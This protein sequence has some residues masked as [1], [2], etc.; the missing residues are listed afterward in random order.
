MNQDLLIEIGTEELPPKS[1]QDLQDAF[2]AGLKQQ[3]TE[4]GIGYGVVTPFCTPRRLAVLLTDVA[5]SQPDRT[6]VRRGPAVAAAFGADEAPT[7][8]LEGFA[9]SCGVGV[10]QL[11]RE[12]NEKGE[13]M[14]F[15]T[16]ERGK[17]TRD[18]VPGVVERAL[19]GLPIAKRMRWGAGEAEFVRPVHWVC[20]LLG[21]EA[22]AGH[23]LG[24]ECGTVT[25]GHRFQSPKALSVG[26][27]SD[28]ASVLRERGFV[29][30][31]FSARRSAIVEQIGA[32]ASQRAVVVDLPDDL[33]DEVTALVEWPRAL[34]GRFEMEFLSVP[35]E[36]LIETMQKNQKYFSVRDRNGAL[37]PEFVVIA[38]IASSDPE[39]V[40]RGNER[41]IRPRFSDAKFFW[42]LGLKTPLGDYF[43]K[44]ENIVYQEKLGSVA[45]RCRRVAALAGEIAGQLGVDADLVRRAA[46][47][48]KCDLATAMVGEFPGLQGTMGRYYAD[49]SGEA[50]EVCAA[51]E[52]QYLPRFAGDAL[53]RSRVGSLLALADRLDLVV[54]AFGI[55]QGPSGT[56]DPYGIRRAA[57]GIVR[58]LVE[59]PVPIALDHLLTAAVRNFGALMPRDGVSAEAGAYVLGRLAGYFAEQGVSADT[60]DAVLA[61]GVESLSD[62]AQRVRAVERFRGMPGAAAL[63]SSNK[64]IANILEKV[65]EEIG[66]AR[67]LA[68][69]LLCEEAE[70]GLLRRIETL[71]IEVL[72]LMERGDYDGALNLLGGLREQVDA[73][74]DAV[75]VMAEDADLRKNR[76]RLLARLRSLFLRV[77]DVSLLQ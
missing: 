64:R 54:G 18:L 35:P 20:I 4:L 29:E 73:F 72:P 6:L 69:G 9:R 67:L 39:V 46:M 43:A 58:L 21:D 14:A 52:E 7:K 63:A 31:S 19:R 24:V 17:D 62:L 16:V 70:I 57:I 50:P 22:V 5:P 47:L 26:T 11:D 30:P 76:L 37:L 65:G 53:P 68:P 3:F 36:A 44:L 34:I 61:A 71:E 40:V 25:Y 8:A 23:V 1:L 28:W 49:R 60:V 51:I 15:R 45:D 41:V 38:N 75:L 13:W 10:D 42:E 74:F 27:A 66:D 77:A 56:K 12:K 55:G 32:I 59:T 48:A 33:V 2:A